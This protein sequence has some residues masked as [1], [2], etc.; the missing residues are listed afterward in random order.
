MRAAGST[1]SSSPVTGWGCH[2]TALAGH[3]AAVIV[4]YTGK[5]TL[6]GQQEKV[7]GGAAVAAG[8]G[9]AFDDAGHTG[10]LHPVLQ[11]AQPLGGRVGAALAA[12]H[13]EAPLLA[14]AVV[15]AGGASPDLA[16]LFMRAPRNG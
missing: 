7:A 13:Q 1:Q 2:F 4:E 12:V 10:G 14:D 9:E 6:A 15:A 8:P 16:L 11:G 5:D 3:R